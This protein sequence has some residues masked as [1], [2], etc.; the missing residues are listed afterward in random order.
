MTDNGL[1]QQPLNLATGDMVT[2]VVATPSTSTEDTTHPDSGAFATVADL[3]QRWHSLTSDEQ[4]K[5][6]SLLDDAADLIRVTCP[7]WREATSQSL[8]R[9]SCAIAR[10]AMQADAIG[11]VSGVTQTSQTAGP[12]SQSFTYSNPTGDLYLTAAEIKALGGRGGQRAFQIDMSQPTR[13]SWW[14]TEPPVVISEVL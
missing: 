13:R 1:P 14:D 10:R 7:H 9:V 3:E 8:I 12:F 6:A 4:V 5:A 2:P 11:D